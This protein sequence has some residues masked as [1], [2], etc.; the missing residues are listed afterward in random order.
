MALYFWMLKLLFCNDISLL[1]SL[2]VLRKVAA[3]CNGFWLPLLKNEP[4]K[5]WTFWSEPLVLEINWWV[6][7]W[8]S[9]WACW[10]ETLCPKILI[11]SSWALVIIASK[12]FE[13]GSPS[14][15]TKTA[16]P[17]KAMVVNPMMLSSASG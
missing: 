14:S 11:C 4:E 13:L 6:T 5:F 3:E 16:G 10:Y 2:S 9:L 12:S 17:T 1:S 7:D 8:M 15:M